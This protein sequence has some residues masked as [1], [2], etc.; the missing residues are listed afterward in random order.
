VR[1]EFARDRL[2]AEFAAVEAADIP[3][4]RVQAEVTRRLKPVMWETRAAIAQHFHDTNDGMG[5]AIGFAA[6]MDEMLKGLHR[7][8]SDLAYP[9]AHQTTGE[10]M[11]LVAL[12]GYGR[13]AL[14]PHSDVDVMFLL[15]YKR[16]A[17]A[18]QIV[19]FILYVL[20]DLS[21]KVGH[22][23]RSV[24]ECVR[25]A[26]TDMVIRTTLLDMRPLAGDEEL[27]TDL[28]KR[29]TRDVL[30]G[31]EKAFVAAKVEER[32]QRLEKNGDSRYRLEPNVKNGQGGLRDLHFI[33]WVAAHLW[34]TTTLE[35]LVERGIFLPEEIERFRKAESFLWTVRTHLHYLLARAEER[36]TF[37]VEQEIA[38]RLGYTARTGALEVE[39]FMKRYFLVAREIGELNRVFMS[40]VQAE[41]GPERRL[42]AFANSIEGFPLRQDQLSIPDEKYFKRNPLDL[43]RIFA[44]SQRAQRPIHPRA[45][46]AIARARGLIG[47]AVRADPAASAL[48]LDILDGDHV[49]ETLAHMSEAG[50]LGRFL[51]DW[52]RVV[53]QMQYDMYHVY[54]VD[55]HTLHV[56]ANLSR[57][58]RGELNET[59]P[60]AATALRQLSSRREL[61][62]ALILHDIA[63]GRGGDH[64]ILGEQVANK[65]CRRLGLGD[66][67]TETVAWLV[68]WH[69]AMSDVAL[70]RDLEDPRTIADFATLVQS[71]ERLKLLLVVTTCDI[72]GVGPGRWNSWK[73]GLF[74]ELYA[75][76]S[77][78]LS[79]TPTSKGAGVRVRV[80]QELARKELADWSDAEFAAFVALGSPGYWLAYDAAAHARHAR[81]I[82]DAEALGET[83]SVAT[84]VDPERA[85]T[86][87]SVYAEDRPLLFSR[88]AGGIAATGFSIADAKILQL[89]NGKVLDVFSVHDVNGNTGDVA[90]RQDMLV[91]MLSRSLAGTLTLSDVFS[92]RSTTMIGRTKVLP[93]PSRVLIDNDLSQTHNVIEING[94]DRPGL[95][96]ALTA[97]LNDIGV[98]VTSAKISTY[99]HRVVDV[100]YVTDHNGAK[101]VEGGWLHHIYVKLMD[102]LNEPVEKAA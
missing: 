79:G 61:Y 27:F 26:K 95:L 51:P 77:D 100:F 14:A 33:Q 3:A 69:L 13:G 57:M 48:F 82:G 102:V 84:R 28:I 10:G 16:S 25:L 58:E 101:I 35:E 5:A 68:R 53:G 7:M 31:G 46:S 85:V 92:R 66:A 97:T 36:L 50:I 89:S 49:A 29:L 81:Q 41:L 74:A 70:K 87:I 32:A 17:R 91:D 15:P 73:A 40:A 34:R 93:A 88:L 67:E 99:G 30:A 76:T 18:E 9:S 37:D 55:E 19:E 78:L 1:L 47:P 60:L 80:A 90:D 12:G 52:A 62:L 24:E 2:Q 21:L 8:A 43:L 11:E 65:V 38:R 22:A 23:V 59:F 56:L 83:L 96:Y 86:E 75:R 39:R 42:L 64:S 72:E 63:K 54:T 71:L 20:W 44:V 4:G 98:R 6:F 45:E 94:R